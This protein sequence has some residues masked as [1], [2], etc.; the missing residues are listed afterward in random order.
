T[1]GANYETKIEAEAEAL[2]KLNMTIY[3]LADMLGLDVSKKTFEKE[4]DDVNSSTYSQY[5][6]IYYQYPEQAQ[7]LYAFEK[8]I[9]TLL[10]TFNIPTEYPAQT[11]EE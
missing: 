9:D 10:E 4:L 3:H 8:C 7:T 2:V 11:S 6:Q 1:M 5:G